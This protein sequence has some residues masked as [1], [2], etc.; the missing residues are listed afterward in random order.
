MVYAGGKNYGESQYDRVTQAIRPPGSAFKPIVYAAA[1]QKGFT[2][3]DMIDDTPLTISK[4]SPH[5]Y[6][7]K[8][9]GRI[10]MYK[11]LMVSSNVCA[12]RVIK[13][14]GVH[15]V[16]QLARV[17]GI[18]TPL[19]KDY[20]IS[21]GSNGVKL[22]EFVRAYSAFSNGGYVVEPYAIQR[23]EDSRGRVLYKAPGVKSSHQ[24]ND[25]TAAQM[26][27]MLKTVIVSGTGTGANIGKPAAGKTGTTDDYKDAYF[28][29]YTPNIV[30][31]VWVGDDNNRKMAGLTGGTV[32]A[33]IW[34]DIMTVATEKYGNKDFDYPE[35]K[36]NGS[37]K[38][39]GEE[40]DDENAEN[41]AASPNDEILKEANEIKERAAEN[42]KNSSPIKPVTADD[43]S[44]TFNSNK[45]P[46]PV[47]KTEN[48][49]IAL[50]ES[51]R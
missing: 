29:G 28:V 45:N 20:T 21:L 34:K 12:A 22:F 41:P 31:G 51:L 7:N 5:N 35:I 37:G 4:W 36:L 25:E 38:S 32:P 39:I 47:P 40:K 24:L 46:A 8:Y 14:I 23:V 10:P 1:L 13:E 26:T 11:A 49:P 27:A 2:P 16:I 9:R 50:P 17:L 19:E 44:K 6:G 3:N 42:A 33:R 15:S 48:I 30:A 18:T 43:I